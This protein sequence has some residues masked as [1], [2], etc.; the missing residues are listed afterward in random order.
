MTDVVEQASKRA[1]TISTSSDININVLE[2]LK[3]YT[4]VVADTGE[5]NAIK[6]FG[7]QDATTNP[8]LIVKAA[9]LPEYQH[10]VTEAVDYSKKLKHANAQEQCDV[11]MDYLA[12]SFGKRIADI[13]PGYVSTEVDAR[14]SFDTLATVA[15]ARRIVSMY[16]ELGIDKQRVLIKIASTYEGIR[17]G[18]ILQK[19]GINC[20]LTLLFSLIQAAA[21]AEANIRLVSPFVGRILDWFKAKNPSKQYAGEE[22]PGVISVKTI[23]HYFKKFGYGT[24][25][26]GASFRNTGQILCLSGCDRLTIAPTLLE[27]MKNNTSTT[28]ERLLEPT[29]AAANYPGDKLAVDEKSFRYALNQ[30]AM[31]TEKL[32]EG[33][34]GFVVDIEKL[35]AIVKAKLGTL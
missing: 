23:Y 28:V 16:E 34:R 1:R 33:I 21:C 14:L 25:V 15:R 29:H 2:Q 31:A 11:A 22:D 24:I 32:A 18:E 10:F 9:I 27:E 20:N 12:V 17:A 6:A 5:I 8:S 4:V 3:R 19:E 30:D 35:E 7:P 13:V 26:M